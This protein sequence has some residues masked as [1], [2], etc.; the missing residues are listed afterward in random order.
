MRQVEP[1]HR[2]DSVILGTKECA[3]DIIEAI[4]LWVFAN[5]SSVA[6]SFCNHNS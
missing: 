5:N 3:I 1:K 4:Y 2:H 6:F